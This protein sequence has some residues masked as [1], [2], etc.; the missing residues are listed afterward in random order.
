MLQILLD[1]LFC[2]L[3]YRGTEVPSRPEMP[4]PAPLSQMRKF[5]KQLV[6][7]PPLDPPHDLEHL[8]GLSHQFS[9]SLRYLSCQNLVAVLRGH[10]DPYTYLVNVLQRES[11]HPARDVEAP[12]PRQWKAK[13]AENPLKSDLAGLGK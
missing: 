8:A 1:H 11:L 5:L 9:D 2:H 12:T 10:P 7:R 13:F 4:A 6:R 3:A